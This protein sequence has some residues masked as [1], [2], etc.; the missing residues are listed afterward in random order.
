M[1]PMSWPS[2]PSSPPLPDMQHPRPRHHGFSLDCVPS[3][4]AAR[5]SIRCATGALSCFAS[6]RSPLHPQQ[7]SIV[8]PGRITDC[9]FA[10]AT[11]RAYRMHYPDSLH[12]LSSSL[13]SATTPSSFSHS[14]PFERSPM[15]ASLAHLK[16]NALSQMDL[17]SDRIARACGQAPSFSVVVLSPR[18]G[19]R[20]GSSHSETAAPSTSATSPSPSSSSSSPEP[21]KAG[22]TPSFIPWD[23][24]RSRARSM[25]TPHRT[26]PSVPSRPRSTSEPAAVPVFSPT[27]PRAVLQSLRAVLDREGGA[28]EGVRVRLEGCLDVRHVVDMWRVQQRRGLDSRGG[29]DLKTFGA[30]VSVAVKCGSMPVRIGGFQHYIP[31]VV[32][33]CVD[34]LDRT[35][36]YKPG[37]FRALPHL[38]RLAKLVADF[39]LPLSRAPVQPPSTLTQNETT[40]ATRP[41]LRKEAT[42]D[43]C[44]LLKTYLDALPEP[45]L[46]QQLTHALHQL[47]VAPTFSSAHPSPPVSSPRA[48]QAQERTQIAL[49]Q[50]VLR[51]APPP[52]LALFVYLAGFFTQVPL[53]PDNGV[54][55]EDVVRMFGRALA[56][57]APDVRP[58]VVLWVLERWS[59]IVDG[60]FEVARDEEDD[61]VGGGELTVEVQGSG[62]GWDGEDANIGGAQVGLGEGEG[63]N[64]R[65]IMSSAYTEAN[66]DDRPNQMY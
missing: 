39:D 51:L 33:A 23:G 49:A 7:P 53:S 62:E 63:R 17:E 29:A 21:A 4:P 50:H 5:G 6:T 66:G 54:S 20:P 35:G 65:H 9:M 15:A 26:P 34:E 48:Q 13:S 36:I 24:S 41:L 45:L 14:Q 32:H 18:A 59:R 56:G 58:A 11:P 10:S 64:L 28:G 25:R 16:L 46:D 19:T 3:A 2:S 8:A 37:L 43:V 61:E 57:G 22:R 40:A 31:W 42:A 38:A 12:S 47:C 27:S 55:L 60:L 30:H 44:A 1:L 52:Q